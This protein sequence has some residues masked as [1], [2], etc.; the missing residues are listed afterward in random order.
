MTAIV[1]GEHSIITLFINFLNF[2]SPP[3]RLSR[4]KNLPL[5]LTF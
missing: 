5:G 4:I 1:I 3:Q 2:L